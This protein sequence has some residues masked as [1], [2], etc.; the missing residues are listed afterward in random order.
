MPDRSRIPR[1]S[2]MRR[3]A[4]FIRT[5]FIAAPWKSRTGATQC[6]LQAVPPVGRS[7]RPSEPTPAAHFPRPRPADFEHT[8]NNSARQNGLGASCI[9]AARSWQT[10]DRTAGKSLFRGSCRHGSKGDPAQCRSAPLLSFA[11]SWWLWCPA[12]ELKLGLG[13]VELLPTQSVPSMVT[14]DSSP[15]FSGSSLT[16]SLLGTSQKLQ[17][18]SRGEREGS[19]LAFSFCRGRVPAALV[20]P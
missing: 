4:V 6:G 10:C 16:N 20:L 1:L 18:E 17:F 15:T 19:E 5:P 3:F 9:R 11:W 13:I 2:C 8:I 7:L 12:A 14:K